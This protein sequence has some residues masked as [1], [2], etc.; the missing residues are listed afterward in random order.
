MNL[1]FFDVD[2]KEN[3]MG[4]KQA[5]ELKKNTKI[6]RDTFKKFNLKILQFSYQPFGPD[7][8]DGQIIIEVSTIEGDEI[9][10]HAMIKVNLYDNNG[11]IFLTECRP[12]NANYFSGYDTFSIALR[13]NSKALKKAKKAR[14]FMTKDVYYVVPRIKKSEDNKGIKA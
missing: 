1:Y 10:E 2:G 13:Y 14:I 12:V 4:E 5:K 8:A 11:E 7:D 3:Y 6:M 9:P